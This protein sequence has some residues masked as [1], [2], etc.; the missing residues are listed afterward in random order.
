MD[1]GQ[2]QNHLKRPMDAFKERVSQGTADLATAKFLL[3]I[4]FHDCLGSAA[5][6]PREAMQ[7]SGAA[8][9][10]LQWLWSSGREDT[11]EFLND[12]KFVSLLVRFLVADGQHSRVLRWMHRYNNLEEKPFSSIHQ[13]DTYEIQR[14][15][16]AV[17]IYEEMLYGDGLESAMALFVRTVAG[18]R[19][20]GATKGSMQDAVIKGAWILIKNVLRIPKAPKLDPNIVRSFMET[21][22]GYQADPLLNALLCI[23]IQE[24]PDPQPT[25]TY[26]QNQPIEAVANLSAGKRPR[27]VLLGLRA[28]ELFLRDDRQT[29]ALWIMEFLQRNFEQELGSPPPRI[30]KYFDMGGHQKNLDR[31]EKSLYLLDKLAIQ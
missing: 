28:A 16:L 31:E 25:L 27:M 11:G 29:E 9:T 20:S 3:G 5:A 30:H 6:T 24:R 12:R 19:S 22:R 23:H 26:L 7:A 1:L 10:V 18:L 13:S 14:R 8:S 4:Q 15:L 21:M 2:L 17:L